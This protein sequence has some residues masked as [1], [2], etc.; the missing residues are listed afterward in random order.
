MAIIAGFL[1]WPQDVGAESAHLSTDL[2]LFSPEWINNPVPIWGISAL[3]GAF[4]LTANYPVSA[5]PRALSGLVTRSYVDDYYHRVH[6]IPAVLDIGNLL[7]VQTRDVSV[8]NAHFTPQALASI[9]ESGTAGLTEFGIVAPTTFGALEERTYSVTVT[10]NGPATIGALYTFAFPDE[11]P[12]LRV[13]GR[14]VVVFGHPPDWTAGLIEGYEFATDVI[15]SYGGI[16]QRIGLRTAPRRTLEYSFNVASEHERSSLS[17]ALYGWQARVFAV[18]IWTD[19]QMLAAPLA[20]GSMSVSCATDGYEFAPT[21]LVVLWADY[22]KHEAI[23]VASVSAT[24]LTFASPT[25]AE[26]PA[27]TQLLPVRLGRLPARFQASR[28]AGYFMSQRAEFTFSDHAGWPAVDSGDTYLGYRVHDLNAR[29]VS[30]VSIDYTRAIE[31]IDYRTAQQ[32]VK[33]RSGYMTEIARWRWIC[34]ERA[35]VVA[36]RS[37]LAARD[38]RR[39]P[40]WTETLT[41]D[42]NVVAIIGASDSSI[43]VENIGYQRYINGRADRRHIAIRTTSGGVYYRQITGAT[44][45]SSTVEQLAIDTALGVTIDPSQ[46]DSVRFLRLSRMESDNVEIDWY[47]PGLAESTAA[48]RSIPA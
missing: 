13:T 5:A 6:V 24:G 36:F 47:T 48:I 41:D 30:D 14:R 29:F 33:D 1:G 25:L 9:A 11:S 45:I 38:G 31:S 2:D 15:E 20:A 46:I 21:G 10:T 4:A 17:A 35:D 12:T 34:G 18:P 44:E 26:W 37:W 32:W 19:A 39:V 40:F 3:S 8:W 16:E 23:E 42:L 27:G 28:V 22:N 43:Q 7:S